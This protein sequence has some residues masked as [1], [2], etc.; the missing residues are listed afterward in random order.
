MHSLIENRINVILRFFLCVLIFWLPYSPAVIESSVVIG[1]LLWGIKRSVACHRLKGDLAAFRLLVTPLNKPIFVFGTVC[2]LSSL[3]SPFWQQSL[4][5]FLTKTLEWFIVY[6]LV[7]EGV[8][9][10]KHIY[11]VLGIF[12][13]TLLA[14]SLDGLIQY[15]V[16][17][18]DIFGGR[19]IEPGTRATAGFKTA[20]AL[21]AYLTCAIPV[22]LAG[23]FRKNVNF[24]N[25]CLFALIFFFTVWLLVVT[26]SRGAW[27]TVFLG[28]VFFTVMYLLIQRRFEF[29]L[30]LGILSILVFLWAYFG[31]ILMDDLYSR[32]LRHETISWRVHI[33]KDTFKMIQDSPWLGH[34]INTFMQI[35]EA[36]RT[37]RGNPA[38]AHNSYLQ[39]AAETGLLGL[40][41]FLWIFVNL[42]RSF[43]ARLA[44]HEMKNDNLVLLAMGLVSGI[45]AFLAHSFFDN[46]F[47]SLQLSVYL[48]F[49]VGLLFV[50][51]KEIKWQKLNER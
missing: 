16:T 38:Y 36:Y 50:M 7:I 9:E 32:P 1:L 2:I 4:P 31:F 23:I 15:Y 3:T 6:F 41:S 20:N 33:W 46:H 49:M 29:Y 43:L 19:T 13:V 34:G 30:V 48:W 21:G 51:I 39:L 17:Y 44:N 47:Y 5:N 24:S 25:R 26:F 11:L 45:F 40:V 22:V 10:R 35:F 27:V 42:F 8:T 14:T 28:V 18:K 37:D 12:T